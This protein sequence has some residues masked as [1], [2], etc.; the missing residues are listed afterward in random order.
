MTFV[1]GGEVEMKICI[2]SLFQ[3]YSVSGVQV[4]ECVAVQ[5]LAF[6]T[7]VNHSDTI[8]VT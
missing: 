7:K 1:L 2:Q 8:V 5:A 3:V 4:T 6:S